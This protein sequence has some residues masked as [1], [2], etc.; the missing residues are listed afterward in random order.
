[1]RNGPQQGPFFLDILG[2]DWFVQSFVKRRHG[3]RANADKESVHKVDNVQSAVVGSSQSRHGSHQH[4]ARGSR[5]QTALQQLGQC[6]LAVGNDA[7]IVSRGFL[8]QQIAQ[9]APQGT[10]TLADR[11]DLLGLFL[12]LGEILPTGQIDKLH[13]GCLLVHVPIVG[14]AVNLEGCQNVTVSLFLA[15]GNRQDVLQ[16]MLPNNNHNNKISHHQYI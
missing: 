6:A 10:Q 16:P 4:H 7:T 15:L 11:N 1:M 8:L 14:A 5:F 2:I 13:H 12:G 3:R 9:N